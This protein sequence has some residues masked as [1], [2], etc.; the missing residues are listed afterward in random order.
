L[1]GKRS[2]RLGAV[3]GVSGPGFTHYRRCNRRFSDPGLCSVNFNIRTGRRETGS[4]MERDRLRIAWRT[5]PPGQRAKCRRV[6]IARVILRGLRGCSASAPLSRGMIGA[7][8]GCDNN[9]PRLPTRRAVGE[10]SD[11]H[12]L[13]II[14]SEQVHRPL[15]RRGL[16]WDFCTSW[17]RRPSGWDC[18]ETQR[19]AAEQSVEGPVIV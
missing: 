15:R 16:N 3:G 6:P 12:N 10:A 1:A 14:E 11:E 4:I 18:L 17:F 13:R 8:T 9:P 5:E 19:T 2:G 7:A